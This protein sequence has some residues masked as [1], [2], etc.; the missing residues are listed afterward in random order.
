MRATILLR[1]I[2]LVSSLVVAGCGGCYDTFAEAIELEADDGVVE[3]LEIRTGPP[4]N[5]CGAIGGVVID[6]R[7]DA[8]LVFD[9]PELAAV[10]GSSLGTVVSFDA[11][12]YDDET[13]RFTLEGVVGTEAV[14]VSW[15]LD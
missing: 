13:E 8:A 2:A 15:S 7:C 9:D 5:T 11:A 4:S 6:N 12:E 3:C 10:P 1:S 14:V